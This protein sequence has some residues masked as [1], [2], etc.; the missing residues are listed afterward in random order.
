MSGLVG[1]SWRY[2]LSWRGS[3]CFGLFVCYNR[4]IQFK[5]MTS[6]HMFRHKRNLCYRGY[7]ES[8]YSGSICV[9][10]TPF[11]SLVSL[12][13]KWKRK[14]SLARE[15]FFVYVFAEN[16][17]SDITKLPL[18]S[19]TF[20][21]KCITV[22]S[23]LAIKLRLGRK[24]QTFSISMFVKLRKIQVLINFYQVSD[25]SQLKIMKSAGICMD[26]KFI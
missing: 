10:I 13:R 8:R 2:I 24:R 12:L 14:C 4:T 25:W 1:D 23:V 9:K 19:C 7:L 15:K 21:H 18:H 16:V 20:H 22:P 11:W 26:R 17:M 5:L 6:R 3:N